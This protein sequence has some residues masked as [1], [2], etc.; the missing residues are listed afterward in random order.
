MKRLLPFMITVIMLI[1]AQIAKGQILYPSYS[2][3]YIDFTTGDFTQFPVE[4]NSSTYAWEVVHVG[5]DYYMK[6]TNEGV[7]NSSSYILYRVYYPYS[8]Y[9][10]FKAKCLGEGTTEL[11][12]KCRFSINDGVKFEHGADVGGDWVTYTFRVPSG[13]NRFFWEY[14]KDSSVNPAGDGFYVKDMAFY[15]DMTFVDFETGD[16]GSE[17]TFTNDATHPWTIGFGGLDYAPYNMISGNSGIANSTSSI[18]T[19]YRFNTDGV[20]SFYAKCMGETGS[21]GSVFDACNFYIDDERVMHEGA[22]GYQDYAFAVS[23]GNHTFKWE[24]SK[25][26]SVDP[27][28]DCFSVADMF[29]ASRQVSYVCFTGFTAPEWGAH[30]DFELSTLAYSRCHIEEIKWH[31]EGG[32]NDYEMH[33]NEVFDHPEDDYYMTVKVMPFS[34]PV[35]F[36]FHTSAY[37]YFDGDNGIVDSP[38]CHVTDDGGYLIRTKPY[39]L[40]PTNAAEHT[41]KTIACWPNPARETLYLEGV[42]G[43]T[44]SVY[45]NTGRMVLQE[46]YNG[47]LNVNDL[48]PGVYAVTVAGRVMKFV[49]E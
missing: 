6:S 35:N 24:Y 8:G 30:P 19:S 26:S 15:P 33:P 27:T 16:F 36:V 7:A 42:D 25:D 2:S 23:E 4:D 31:R 32:G 28:G 47:K 40:D 14:S 3:V 10:S 34:N 11:Y 1:V 17:L 29:F 39:R 37:C 12:D 45:D 48:V 46:I 49:K 5:N 41:M 21:S 22:V 44:V 13:W 18:L 20:I 38:N 43:E 9:L